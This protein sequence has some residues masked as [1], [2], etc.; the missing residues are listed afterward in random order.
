[1]RDDDIVELD[2]LW[3]DAGLGDQGTETKMLVCTVLFEVSGWSS[4]VGGS[5][6]RVHVR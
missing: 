2:L 4:R 3:V 1:M 5:W 6:G